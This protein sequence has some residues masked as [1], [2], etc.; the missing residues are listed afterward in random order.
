MA[1]NPTDRQ[2]ADYDPPTNLDKMIHRMIPDESLNIV[3]K[4]E[5]VMQ[6]LQRD[7][8]FFFRTKF[9]M[10]LEYDSG[11]EDYCEE[12]AEGI[13]WDMRSGKDDGGGIVKKKAVVDCIGYR[14]A[15][16]NFPTGFNKTK[17]Q[18]E[19]IWKDAGKNSL[20]LPDYEVDGLERGRKAAAQE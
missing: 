4:Q 18:I 5:E 9:K 12:V 19:K 14:M 11:L 17:D 10:S 16:D 1:S 6:H 8:E 13:T 2:Q 3:R 20:L 15:M 7:L